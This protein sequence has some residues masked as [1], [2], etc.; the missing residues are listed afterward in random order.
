M[1][2]G[3]A[4]MAACGDNVLAVIDRA[5]NDPG[6]IPSDAMSPGSTGGGSA[7]TAATGSGGLTSGTSGSTAGGSSGGTTTAGDVDGGTSGLF[8]QPRL[9]AAIS[10]PDHNDL[11][12]ALSS[13]ELELYF[14]SDRAGTS[15]IWV[16]ERSSPLDTW[17]PPQRVDELSS[18]TY[19]DRSPALSWDGL[20]MW[21]A[22]TRPWSM[23]NTLG[24]IWTSTR[25]SRGVPWTTPTPV[26][27]LASSQ[28]DYGP[29]VDRD[30]LIMF[31]SSNR[32]GG[33][34][35]QDLYT[36]RRTSTSAPWGTPVAVQELNT[37]QYEWDPFISGDAL[38]IFWT[39]QS[40]VPQHISFATRATTQAPFSNPTVLG[41][42]GIGASNPTLSP[43]LQ[44]I[45]FVLSPTPDNAELY[46][47]T[48][49]SP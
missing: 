13:D 45:V 31:F 17:N 8:G 18:N 42:L 40:F 21:F 35:F 29:S 7:G 16:S 20:T 11:D 3:A 48:R 19:L 25:P 34:G 38:T 15:D 23:G 2:A 41:E 4:A 28:S 39:L 24:H 14:A 10:D 26:A 36:A 5:P 12:P 47:A 6:G 49:I 30:G 9:I 33:A 37:G 1:L 22:S 46:E 43:D 27:E 32:I 44:R